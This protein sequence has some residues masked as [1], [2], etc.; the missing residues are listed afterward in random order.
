MKQHLLN[1]LDA[2]STQF[3]DVIAWIDQH[4]AFSPTRFENGAQVNEANQ[5][6][7]SCKVFAL[8][9]R[10]ELTQEETL[11]LFC[12][13]YQ[14]VLHHPDGNDHQNIRQFMQHGYTGLKFEGTALELLS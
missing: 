12:E 7:G 8:G 14:A 11:R 3:S 9:L 6:N 1:L 2:P 13:H 4:F 10:L 5:N